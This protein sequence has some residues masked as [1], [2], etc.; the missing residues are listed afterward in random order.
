MTAASR[1]QQCKELFVGQPRLV[2]DA[3]QYV[4]WEI[5]SHMAGNGNPSR[6]FRMLELYVRSAALVNEPSRPL[7]STDRLLVG[8]DIREMDRPF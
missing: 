7:Q 6:P 4:L 8:F 2:N 1:F 3:F 5:K